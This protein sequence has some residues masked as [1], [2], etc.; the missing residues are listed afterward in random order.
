MPLQPPPTDKHFAT[1][2]EAFTALQAHARNEGFA[3]V[4]KRPSC[5]EDGKPRRYDIACVRGNGAYKPKSAGLRK[6]TTKRTGCPFKMKIV[7]RKDSD[8]LW[9]P[10]IL[11]GEH[12]HE[13][14]L[15]IAFPEHRRGALTDAQKT[16]IRA[17]LHHSN[18]SARGIIEVLK[19]QYPDVLLTEKDIW[20]LRRESILLGWPIVKDGSTTTSTGITNTGT[21]ST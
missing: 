10:G 12:N 4:K 9:V 19:H 15:P 7:Q 8:D 1:S 21:T 6:S 16:I 5:Y 13:P 17:L 3:M 11:C 14:D 2:D 20:N 18:L